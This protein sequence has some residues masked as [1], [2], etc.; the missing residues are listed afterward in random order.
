MIAAIRNPLTAVFAATVLYAVGYL[1]WYSLTP[2]GL[3][4][5]L[6]G[7]E[8]L[9]LA[10][11]IS[12]GT[13]PKEAFYRAPLYPALLSLF[14][15][16]GLSDPQ[17][18]IAARIVNGACHIVSTVLIM[19]IAGQIWD[20][21][22]SAAVAG[23]LFGLNPVVLHFVGDPLDITL[24]LT[25]ML[26]GLYSAVHAD[27]RLSGLA[28][29]GLF[30]SL[31]T[32]TRP[33]LLPLVLAWPIIA[34]VRPGRGSSRWQRACAAAIGPA[35]IFAAFGIAN[36]SIAN[37]FRLLPWQGA[38]NLWAANK[39]ESNGRYYQ[40]TTRVVATDPLTN[41]TRAESERLYKSENP[42]ATH[43][44]Y[45]EMSRYWRDKTIGYIAAHPWQWAG[46]MSTKVFYFLN[47]FEQYNNKTYVFHKRRSPWLRFNPICWALLLSLGVAGATIGFRESRMRLII[48][49]GVLLTLA[50][51]LFFVSARFR[52]PLVPLLAI[53]AGWMGR[54]SIQEWRQR[55]LWPA[56]LAAVIAGGISLI[57]IDKIEAEKTIVAD[58]VL[59][60][61]AASQLHRHAESADYAARALAADDSFTP[62]IELLCLTQFNQ[63]FERYFA[64][65]D[66]I[67]I[68]AVT[69]SCERAA[70]ISDQA[71]LFWGVLKLHHGEKQDA[72]SVWQD[73]I[74]SDST[75]MESALAALLLT[76]HLRVADRDF[77]ERI[78]WPARSL[79]L[80]IALAMTGDADAQQR[81][82][83]NYPLDYI[84]LQ[85]RI[86][87]KLYR[88]L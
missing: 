7:R 1:A 31:A 85:M 28:S 24:A 69:A 49:S 29:C 73:L 32:L 16:A 59:I 78:P 86:F 42:N 54:Y 21:P 56:A 19:N 5:V 27:G 67:S 34:T 13:L 20:R 22:R 55:R 63:W 36:Y 83:Q 74:D 71:Q 66:T 65:T 62:A 68:G 87:G 43:S 77:L 82:T 37:D 46:L 30:W 53:L 52:L 38:Y 25:L 48:I 51:S 9:A 47:N 44:E 41:P 39:P 4:P 81:L 14:A 23:I 80:L 8:L 76:G 60:S 11:A 33:N 57:P 10:K 3:Y 70:V 15:S 12:A 50:A 79:E 35:V 84:K 45:G 64:G 75:E 18:I 2:L 6:D 88:R 40:Q 72:R 61:K 58:L 17:L 26:I